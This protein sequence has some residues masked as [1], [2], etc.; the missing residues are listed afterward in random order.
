M[1]DVDYFLNEAL[2]WH[3]LP[4]HISV[5]ISHIYGGWLPHGIYYCPID[6]THL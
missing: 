4:Q 6:K 2:E 5:Q 1:N 3:V